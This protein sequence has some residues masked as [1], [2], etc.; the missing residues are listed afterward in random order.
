MKKI[1]CTLLLCLSTFAH[2]EE[3]SER[4]LIKDNVASLFTAEQFGELNKLATQYRKSEART[5]SGLW[6][7]TVFYMGLSQ[8]P[9]GQITDERYWKELEAKAQKWAAAYPDSPSG[10]L[11]YAD[12]LIHHAWMYRGSEF[13]S[14]VRKQDWK[15][16]FE[17]IAKA[18]K[19]LLD[20]KTDASQDPRWYEL[21]LVVARAEGWGMEEFNEMVDEAT[22]RH[23]YSYQ[24]YFVAI[25]Y[26]MPNWHGSVQDIENFAQKAAKITSSGE[27]TGMYARI[28]WY[29]SQ[30]EYGP[31]LFTKT[32]V[33]WDKMSVAIND[34]L[35]KYPDQWNINN[36][37][38][39]S[40]MAGD[41]KQTKRLISMVEGKPNMKVWGTMS[42]FNGCKG[43]SEASPPGK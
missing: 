43:W 33:V 8:I 2:G 41:A 10:H 20:H 18:K 4:R 13:A 31:R 40:C 15:P 42:A 7:L 26:L 34:V 32:K 16:Y 29:A 35:E 9:D 37:A 22:T 23:P 17:Q 19:Y 12:I 36:F 28:Y 21:A 39:F 27:K 38:Y 11:V 3:M 30:A 5:P 24:T 6:K 25:D 14:E 1:I